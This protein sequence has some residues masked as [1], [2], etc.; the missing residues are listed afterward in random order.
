M[1]QGSAE[2]VSKSDLAK[3]ALIMV[4][5]NIGS[6][7]QLHARL[8][9]VTRVIF[10]G[11]FLENNEIAMRTLA[12]A[13]EFWSQGK[14]LALFLEHI[15]YSGAVGALISAVGEDLQFSSVAAACPVERE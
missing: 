15:G 2:D 9:G 13:L 10:A 11:N 1:A 12:F 5:N 3:A 4:T 8:E 7:V 6:I 14:V